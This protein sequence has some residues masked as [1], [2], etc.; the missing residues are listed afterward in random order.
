MINN[1]KWKSRRWLVT[2]WAI[3]MITFIVVYSLVLKINMPWTGSLLTILS[4]IPIAFIGGESY[5]KT[6][7]HPQSFVESEGK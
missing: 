2:V 1:A 3:C 4:A 5:T 6:R 7:I